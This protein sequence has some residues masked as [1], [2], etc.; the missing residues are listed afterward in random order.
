[1]SDLNVARLVPHNEQDAL[2]AA[3]CPLQTWLL[4]LV[5]CSTAAST[6]C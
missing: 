6:G 4:V 1:M 5:M 2:L 3:A